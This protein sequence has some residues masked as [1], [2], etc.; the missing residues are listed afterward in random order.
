M[1]INAKTCFQYLSQTFYSDGDPVL[2][3]TA[4]QFTLTISVSIVPAGLP[5]AET[6]FLEVFLSVPLLNCISG[7]DEKSV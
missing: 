5:W 3:V 4:F 1:D 2:K 7:V 6:V